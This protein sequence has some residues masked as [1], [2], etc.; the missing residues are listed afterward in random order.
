MRDSKSVVQRKENQSKTCLCNLRQSCAFC[1][2]G[3][4]DIAAAKMSQP[5]RQEGVWTTKCA[6]D[7]RPR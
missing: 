3:S 2:L 1:A 5:F 4:K 7:E 6:E